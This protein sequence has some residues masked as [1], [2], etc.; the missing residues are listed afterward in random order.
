MTKKRWVIAVI[1]SLLLHCVF[2]LGVYYALEHQ[3][4]SEP[5]HMEVSMAEL[6]QPQVEMAMEEKA[7]PNSPGEANQQYSGS[8]MQVDNQAQTGTVTSFSQTESVSEAISSGIRNTSAENSTGTGIVGSQSGKPIGSS[9]GPKVVYSQEP[10]Y[11]ERARLNGWE[12]TVRLRFIVN[13]QG[14]VDEVTVVESSGH[15]EIDQAAIDCIKQWRFSPALKAGVP[16]AAAV[17]MPVAFDL[18]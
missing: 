15:R 16:I 8:T 6:F 11:P 14:A 13:T 10:V 12:G 18:R 3:I 1:G 4:A 17:T 9:R 2:M 5:V 7:T